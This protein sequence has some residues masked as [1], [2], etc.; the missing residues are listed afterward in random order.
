MS[1]S[2]TTP[3]TRCTFGSS[4]REETHHL[5]LSL[6]FN[7]LTFQSAGFISCDCIER[8][9]IVVE[10]EALISLLISW[11][12]QPVSN[13]KTICPRWPQSCNLAELIY[14][15]VS[16][17]HGAACRQVTAME[18]GADLEWGWADFLPTAPPKSPISP[19]GLVGFLSSCELIS[20]SHLP[21]LIKR[22]LQPTDR[23]QLMGKEAT[24]SKM[25]EETGKLF[26][27]V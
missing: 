19:S 24:C 3:S 17:V 1:P 10:G 13:Q 9:L 20:S 11:W 26:S 2:G 16:S 27:F 15:K 12:A 22:N 7:A 6:I 4:S 25:R 8:S 21:L 5:T 14:S 23:A 18:C